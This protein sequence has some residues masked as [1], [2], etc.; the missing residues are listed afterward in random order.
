M[1]PT[2][3]Q[4]RVTGNKNNCKDHFKNIFVEKLIFTRVVVSLL[5]LS[6]PIS[7]VQLQHHIE[8]SCTSLVPIVV[9]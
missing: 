9:V 7:K 3:C 4:V 6:L 1:D 5:E 8:T 2:Y